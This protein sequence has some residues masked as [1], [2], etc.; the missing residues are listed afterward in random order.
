MPQI[1]QQDYLRIEVPKGGQVID[2]LTEE[3]VNELN[4][5]GVLFDV[6]IKQGGDFHRIVSYHVD[7]LG[8]VTNISYINEDAVALVEY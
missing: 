6:I 5:R 4:K 1:A 2:V 7:E 8:N 3:K